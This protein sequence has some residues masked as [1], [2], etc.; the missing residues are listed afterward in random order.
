MIGGDIRLK[1]S[2][3]I[4]EFL[5][6][7]MK[8]KENKEEQVE[9]LL[10]DQNINEI[11]FNSYDNIYCEIDN[12]IVRQSNIF[13]DKE[14]YH[15][16]VSS[17]LSENNI[18]VNESFPI[19]DF[20]IGKDLRANIIKDTI[21]QNDLVL[22]IRRRKMDITNIEDL[23]KNNFATIDVLNYLVKEMKNKK[24]IFISG[25]TSTGKTTLLNALLKEL[26]EEERI[27]IIEDTKE[28][29]LPSNYNAINLVSREK[30]YDSKEVSISDLI[31]TSLRMRPDR[32]I[33]GEI[34]REEVLQYI[35]ALNTGHS[36]SICT[37]H[38]KS[39]KDMINRL[40]ML[41]LEQNIPLSAIK[42]QLGRS[43]D[44][45]VHLTRNNNNNRRLESI[46]SVNYKNDEIILETILM[47]DEYKDEYNY[48]N[49]TN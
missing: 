23:S 21:S 19:V 17:L 18:I 7:S 46:D 49:Y 48:K 34:R 35:H 45:I 24:N 16:F 15:R 1:E 14:Q 25:E 12:K 40:T 8:V 43:I 38:S 47:Y 37:G 27:I 36:G 20:S 13:E 5:R 33:L 41:L 9:K 22:S 32:I 30:I 4:Y 42:L 2:Y 28:I 44:Y 11:M 31:K 39:G 29:Q 6:N 10:N 3:M 26:S